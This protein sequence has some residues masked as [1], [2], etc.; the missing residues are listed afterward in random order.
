MEK[1]AALPALLVELFETQDNLG[2]FVYSIPIQDPGVSRAIRA[3]SALGASSAERMALWFVDELRRRGLVDERFFAHLIGERPE[4]TDRIR[5]VQQQW[6]VESDEW[7]RLPAAEPS[8]QGRADA[9]TVLVSYARNDAAFFEELS[10]QLALLQRKGVI[11]M[12]HEGPFRPGDRIE[13]KPRSREKRR[14][15]GS[16]SSRGVVQ[17]AVARTK[18]GETCPGRSAS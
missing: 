9:P 6:L 3:G 12:W 4:S 11:Q 13:R 7:N 2:R 16:G 8:V 17:R 14:S 5:A 1:E 15:H 18:E 10:A